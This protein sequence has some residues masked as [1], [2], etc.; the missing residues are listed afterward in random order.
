MVRTRPPPSYVFHFPARTL[1]VRADPALG[2]GQLPEKSDIFMI[3]FSAVFAL[4][5]AFK[6]FAARRD[7]AFARWIP[8][9]VAFAIGFLNTPSFSL[10]RLIGGFVEFMYHRRVGRET[11][12]IRL[13]IIASG[14]VLG[15]GVVSVVSLILRTL[16]VGVISCIGCA[17]GLCGRCPS[18]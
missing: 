18:S 15:E 16:G 9:G 6:A 10:A 4:V 17:P 8:S 3:A 13:I 11:G 5:A 7:L 2:D 12:G 1:Y 14:F